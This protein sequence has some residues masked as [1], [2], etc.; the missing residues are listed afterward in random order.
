MPSSSAYERLLVDVRRRLLRFPEPLDARQVG[1]VARDQWKARRKLE[2]RKVFRL[3]K[4]IGQL[5]AIDRRQVLQNAERALRAVQSNH[6]LEVLAPDVH[7]GLE[8]VVE[9]IRHQC[10][11]VPNGADRGAV[12]EGVD[13]S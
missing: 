1:D 7:A 10:L 2:V 11:V 8:M 4:P 5:D 3:Y 9:E 6:A 12:I 13:E